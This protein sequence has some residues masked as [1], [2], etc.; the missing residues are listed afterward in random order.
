MA[1]QAEKEKTEQQ[2]DSSQ[3]KQAQF[4]EAADASPASSEENLDLLLDI[5]VPITV[6]L[7]KTTVPLKRLLQLGPEYGVLAHCVCGGRPPFDQ[8]MPP[9]MRPV[10]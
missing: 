3:V 2:E 9:R 6:T 7:G 10:N 8:T 4:S 5:N 1:E